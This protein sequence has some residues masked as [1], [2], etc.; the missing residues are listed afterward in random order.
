MRLRRSVGA[1]GDFS[2]GGQLVAAAEA[3]GA[4]LEL[5]KERQR[6]ARAEQLLS[7]FQREYDT[8][9]LDSEQAERR[10]RAEVAQLS[11]QLADRD[12]L[13]VVGGAAGAAGF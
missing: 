5:H 9:L 10:W 1:G 13:Q 6:R 11:S 4:S 2:R 3:A 12:T 7:E 8:A